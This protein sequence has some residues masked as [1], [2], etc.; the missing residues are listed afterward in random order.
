MVLSSEREKEIRHEAET[1]QLQG[2]CLMLRDLLAELTAV[3]EEL[4]NV[5]EREDT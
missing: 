5:T 4:R 2:L 3:R 1:G